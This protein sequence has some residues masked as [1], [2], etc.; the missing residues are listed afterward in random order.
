MSYQV[1][2][3][4]IQFV[5]PI[6]GK[7]LSGGSVY[8]GRQ[9]SDPKNQPAN[10]INVYAVQDNGT[11]VLLAQPITLNGAG[12]PQY[13][14]SVKQIKVDL[15]T[16]ESA[17]CVQVFSSSGSQKGYSARV[18]S[19]VDLAS[20]AAA[21][22][23]VPIGG[24]AAGIVAKHVSGF[25]TPEDFGALGNGVNDDTAAWQAAAATGLEIRC[26]SE[27]SY[28]VSQAITLLN[29]T[30]VD[31]R[32]SSI[33][34]LT[35]QTPI[36]NVVNKSGVTIINGAFN[37]KAEASYINSSASNAV[38][39][40]AT[41]ASNLLV[42]NNS[43][44]GFYYSPLKCL[45]GGVNIR[46]NNNNVIGIPAVLAVDVNRRNTT[47]ATVIGVNVQI[48]GNA[49]TGV[50]SGL[51]VGQ[52]STDVV[53]SE[54][55]I[56]ST[57]NEHGIYA[58]TGI[59]RLAITNNIIFGTGTVGTGIKVQFYDSFGVQPTATNVSD[60]IIF[61][62]GSDGI[63]VNNTTGGS[64]TITL[65]GLTVSDNVITNAGAYGLN[66][67]YTEDANINGN[68][69]INCTEA[70]VAYGA[71]QRIKIHDN[72]VRGAG[73]CGIRD[74]V[75]LSQFVSIKNNEIYNVATR[76]VAGDEFGILQALNSTNVD[77]EGNRIND[78]NSNMQYGIFFQP[79]TNANVRLSGNRAT[80]A[81]DTGFRSVATDAF[82]E[83]CNNEFSGTLGA[84]FNSPTAKVVASASTITL[85]QLCEVVSITGTT[86]I[87][88]ITAT[89]RTNSRVT[90]VFGGVLT[91]GIG[92]NIKLNG[93]AFAAA[94]D[95]SLTLVCDGVNWYG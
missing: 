57:V 87:D 17:Y 84:A 16:G 86:N 7:P 27:K 81:T 38:A 40:L 75:S 51:I 83:F 9:D 49:I 69:V 91:V 26:P 46:F 25:V 95:K 4:F 88:N 45:S 42:E 79:A 77:V 68:N 29:G 94:A 44:N 23:T 5:D 11:E 62:T 52:G 43:F 67:R 1:I 6:N 28:L 82:N 2:N 41:G 58:D 73:T 89:G 31:L 80:G 10:R 3:P 70:G 50:A 20:L 48:K 32:S 21:N 71:S 60:N 34:Q 76:N 14:G 93:G 65:V 33:T 90:L 53:V 72:K 12:Q 64:P 63:L 54:N 30:L 36:F 66:I 74:V 61:N 8:F 13:S 19:M 47:G 15:Y 24:V 35:D 39:I 37:G 78:Q 59:R 56:Y 18:Y 92:G 22:S 85:P 55:I